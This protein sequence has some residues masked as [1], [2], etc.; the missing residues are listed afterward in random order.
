[1]R[2]LAYPLFRSLKAMAVFRSKSSR[3]HG[4]EFPKAWPIAQPP[5]STGSRAAGRASTDALRPH[6]HWILKKDIN[7]ISKQRETLAPR[8][9]GAFPQTKQ[10]RATA[11]LHVCKSG[12]E[13]GFMVANCG[14][15]R[16]RKNSEDEWFA[17]IAARASASAHAA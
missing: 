5:G 3:S 17:P 1:M 10:R 6:H 2:F 15:F 4:A 12:P 11:S 8:W 13:E 7:E 16:R 14:V 9:A